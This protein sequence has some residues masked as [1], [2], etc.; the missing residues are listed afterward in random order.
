MYFTL[1]CFLCCVSILTV[2]FLWAFLFLRAL[3]GFLRL[4]FLCAAYTEF[5]LQT[6]TEVKILL[7]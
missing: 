3:F 2:T 5:I 4:G 7:D 6:E 1:L